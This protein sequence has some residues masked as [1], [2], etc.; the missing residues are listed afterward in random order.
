MFYLS[1]IVTDLLPGFLYLISTFVTTGLVIYFGLSYVLAKGE[2][3]DKL[4]VDFKPILKKPFDFILISCVYGFLYLLVTYFL[5]FLLVFILGSTVF[6]LVFKTLSTLIIS[7]V[8]L[9]FIQTNSNFVLASTGGF[10]L[11]KSKS[12]ELLITTGIAIIY[13][14]VFNSLTISIGLFGIIRFLLL[15]VSSAIIIVSVAL[16]GKN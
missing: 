4:K 3:I 10:K 9:V 8:L 14:I 2:V 7:V 13:V 1:V 16:Y 6:I 11:L 5:G 12:K 15:E